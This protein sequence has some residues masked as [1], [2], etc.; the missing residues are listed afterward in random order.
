MIGKSLAHYEILEQLG[1]GGMG[2]VYRARDTRLNREV[3]LKVLPAEFSQDEARRRRFLREAQAIAALKHP[4][5]VTVHAVEESDGVDFIAMELVDGDT[6]ARRIPPGGVTLDDFFG[7]AIPLA[8]AISSAHDQGITHRDLK[9]ANVMLDRDGRLKVL[10][11]GL[12]KLLSPPGDDADAETVVDSGDTGVGQVVGTT[13]YMSPE[14]A[15]GKPIDHRSDI[16]SLGIVLYELATGERPFKG[17][18]QI[19]TI[20]AILKDQPKHISEVRREMPRHVGRIVNRCLEKSP[21]RRFQSAK[22]VR[23]DLESLKR[24]IDS[25]ELTAEME[26]GVATTAAP[27]ASGRRVPVLAIAATAVIIVAVLAWAF[28]PRGNEG[29][30][31]TA[32]RAVSATATT[33]ST[34]ATDRRMMAVVLPFDNLG[35]KEDAY[36][37]AGM[38]DELTSRLSVVKD[39]GVISR[40]SAKQ[41]DRTGKTMR[42]IGEDLGVDYVVEGSVRFAKTPGG[43]GRVRITA[44]LIHVA[45]DTQMW[46]DTYDRDID[47]VFTVQTEIASNV[48]DE[49]GVTLGA[50]EREKVAEAPTDNMEAYEAYVRGKEYNDPTGDFVAEDVETVRLLELATELDPGFLDAWAELSKHH[51]NV[52][53]SPFDKTQARIDAARDALQKAEAIDPDDPRTLVARGDYYY[54]CFRDYDR[55]LENFLAATRQAPSDAEAWA[56][57][58]YIY[59]RQGRWAEHIETLTKALELDPRNDNT[60]GNLAESYRALREFE[61]AMTYYDRA[62]E[63]APDNPMARMNKAFAVASGSGDDDAALA[64]LDAG[65]PSIPSSFA[66]CFLNLRFRRLDAARAAVQEIPDAGPEFSAYR[67]LLIALIK[68]TDNGQAAAMDD[69]AR[70]EDAFRDILES[71]PANVQI[72]SALATALALQGRGDEAVGEQRLAVDLTVKDAYGGPEQLQN[73]AAVYAHTGRHDEALDLLEQ[74]LDTNYSGAITV[75]DLQQ[76]P[77][78][79][80]LRELPRFKALIPPSS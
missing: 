25:G 31:A 79:D 8:D 50:G 74:L 45:D 71:S 52:Y 42:Q 64:V 67:L 13:A 55:A 40:T 68:Y 28:W 63:I 57:V 19:S 5:I 1:S 17:D 33:A 41:Y 78:W 9:P 21:D 27:P 73:L 65:R 46:S 77:A 60:A 48:V 32:D 6:L 44:L 4:N 47:D 56:S 51:S 76:E 22:D 54:Y 75:I 66:R 14:Q 49:L 43:T 3:A 72:R 12:A 2:D 36:F 10:D 59:R 7:Y 80:P 61:P 70:A 15:E 34:P 37:A 38:T 58:A 35:S 26:S 39:I 30:R 20:S 53:N 18:T 16:F 69:F 29:T 62:L 11:F 23:N 24:E